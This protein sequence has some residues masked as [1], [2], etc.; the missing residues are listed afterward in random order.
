MNMITAFI[1]ARIQGTD[2]FVRA[3]KEDPVGV[4]ASALA[5]ITLPSVL[6]WW[7]NKDDPRWNE[8]PD[9]QKAIFWIVM[10]DEHVYRIPKPQLPG[11][12][13]GTIP[14]MLLDR[15]VADNPDALRYI[16]E[17][18]LNEFLSNPVPQI[19]TPLI[20]QFANRSLFTGAPIVPYKTEKLLPEYQFTDYTTET[21]KALSLLIHDRPGRDFR[22]E[23]NTFSPAIMENYI[24]AWTGGLGKY[25][26]QLADLGLRK[27]GVVPDPIKPLKHL[28]DYPIIRAFMIRYPSSSAKSLQDFYE[29]AAAK[30]KVYDTFKEKA[31]SDLKAAQRVMRLDQSAFVQLTGIRQSLSQMNSVVQRVHQNPSMTPL[32][33]QQLIDDLYKKMIE[34]A[35]FGNQILDQTETLFQP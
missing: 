34:V 16:D 25:A 18:I 5:S 15:Y 31:T 24:R 26:L 12:I 11:L 19:A 35:R 17:A 7:A 23:G 1:N 32:Q 2:R 9:W 10:T 29:R 20:E 30:Q 27:A 6:L 28:E 4:S 13:F 8:I 22:D 14:E 3:I 33:K 21:M